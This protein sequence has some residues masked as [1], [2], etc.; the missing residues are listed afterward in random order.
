[1]FK[2]NFLTI[3]KSTGQNFMGR[4][5]FLSI[6]MGVFLAMGIIIWDGRH[7]LRADRLTITAIRSKKAPTGLDDSIWRKTREISVP[8]KGRDILAHEE[9]KVKI[10]ALYTHRNVY[11]RLYW[12]DPSRSITKQSWTF[13]GKTWRHLEGNEDRIALVFEITRMKNFARL[14]F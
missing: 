5:L 1:M 9:G 13:N 3:K 2:R 12:D 10:R 7:S 4:R 11:F 14:I 6:L 8:V